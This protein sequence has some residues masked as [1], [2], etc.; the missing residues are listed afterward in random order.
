M[1]FENKVM[2]AQPINLDTEEFLE[3]T[4]ERVLSSTLRDQARIQRFT[5]PE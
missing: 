1:Y 3:E 5:N 4:I 2:L